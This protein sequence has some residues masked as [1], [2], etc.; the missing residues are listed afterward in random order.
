MRLYGEGERVWEAGYYEEEDR[1]AFFL[2]KNSP[3]SFSLC[4]LPL[5][6]FVSK[7]EPSRSSHTLLSKLSTLHPT[8]REEHTDTTAE[9]SLPPVNAPPP[10]SSR[11]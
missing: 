3:Q 7:T 11:L 10:P 9:T 6:P 5:L 1:Q 2:G 4:L 8:T